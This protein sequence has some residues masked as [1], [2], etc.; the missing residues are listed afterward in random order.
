MILFLIT[1]AQAEILRPFSSARSAGQGSV[2]ITTGLYEENFYYNPARVLANPESRFTLIQIAPD[3]STTT[4]TDS[5]AISGSPSPKTILS[6]LGHYEHARIQTTLPSYYYVG[7]QW[8]MAIGLLASGEV[9]GS[10]HNSYAIDGVGLG[11]AAFALSFAHKL[12]HDQ[13]RLG[14]N[15]RYNGRMLFSDKVEATDYFSGQSLSA[16][17]S[18]TFTGLLDADI[19]ATAIITSFNDWELTGALVLSD[20]LAPPLNKSLPT[21]QPFSTS[22]GV[23]LRHEPTLIR[24]LHA[25]TFAVELRDIGNNGSG[26]FFRLLHF[27]AET[28]VWNK[29]IAFRAGINQGYLTAGIG[30]SL[31]PLTIDIA[32]YG[33]EIA[34]NT[35]TQEDRRIMFSLGL[36]I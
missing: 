36:H 14:V 35:G 1:I 30:L 25:T 4:L 12:L 9:N 23:A 22:M 16:L 26:S 32:T 27:G 11:D 3:I 19:G 33:E 31:L 24:A 5:H 34:L 20:I 15:I 18:K 2:I 8:A 10:L 13:A 6:L 17:G 28:H 29:H 21:S 7:E